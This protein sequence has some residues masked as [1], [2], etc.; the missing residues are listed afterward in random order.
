MLSDD[1]ECSGCLFGPCKVVLQMDTVN[2]SLI[3]NS[4]SFAL[5]L[6]SLCI[7]FTPDWNP[8]LT[9][10]LQE[11]AIF[12]FIIIIILFFVRC[13]AESD[14]YKQYLWSEWVRF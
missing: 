3:I 14:K 6:P 4:Y 8:A 2:Q 5:S 1:D 11:Y 7:D 9:S 10:Q 12:L 13:S